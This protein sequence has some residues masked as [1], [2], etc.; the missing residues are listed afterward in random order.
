LSAVGCAAQ[1]YGFRPTATAASSENGFPASHYAVPA[2]APRGEAYVTSFGTRE[3]DEGGAAR[4]QLIHVRLAVA[5]QSDEARWTLD[6]G[7]LA[8]LAPGG[9]PQRPDFMEIDGRQNGSTEIGRGQRR[10][11]DVYFRM[12]GGA[13]DAR[14]VPSFDFAWQINL[15]GRVFAERT[16]FVREPYRDYNEA[17]RQYVAVGV[18]APWWYGWYGPP[19]WGWPYGPYYGYGPRVGIGIGVGVGGYYG[20]GPRYR[21][22]YGGGG[23]RGR[24]G[25]RGGRR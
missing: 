22:G 23:G 16:S 21:G 13:A 18:A 2:E 19:W 15:G 11:F 3:V 6:P 12:P 9:A 4:S 8:L 25:G 1:Q 20:G 24:G 5:N 17:D 14:N 7:Q 10:M